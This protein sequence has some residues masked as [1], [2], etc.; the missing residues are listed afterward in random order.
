[1]H[2]YL[3]EADGRIAGTYILRPNQSDG[4]SHVANAGLM[5]AAMAEHCSNEARRLGFRAMQ[6]NFV[7]STNT[8]AIRLWQELGFEIAGTLPGAFG[9]LKKDTWMFM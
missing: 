7:I 9:I 8:A 5:V 4:G 1:M 6:F 3:V 2:T